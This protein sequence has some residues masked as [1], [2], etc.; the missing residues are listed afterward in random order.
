MLHRQPRPAQ[1]PALDRERGG[2]PV[3]GLG[4]DPAALGAAITVAAAAGLVTLFA[5][6]VL[7]DRVGRT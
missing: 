4:L 2:L 1:F 3:A 5:G 7:A 6:G